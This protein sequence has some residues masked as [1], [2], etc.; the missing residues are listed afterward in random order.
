MHYKTLR[1]G[2]RSLAE[3]QAVFSDGAKSIWV[4]F[5]PHPQ[6]QIAIRQKSTMEGSRL[7]ENQKMNFQSAARLVETLENSAP[8]R[9]HPGIWTHY[10]ISNLEIESSVL[11]IARSIRRLQ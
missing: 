9:T 11:K 1:A 4:E 7:D 8:P 10:S 5:V 3:G 6:T 2:C